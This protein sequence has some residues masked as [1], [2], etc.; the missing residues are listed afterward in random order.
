MSSPYSIKPGGSLKLKGDKTK[1]VGFDYLTTRKKKRS[2]T[3]EAHGKTGDAPGI[4]SA[5]RTSTKAEQHFE[6]VQ[7][8]R[9]C[10]LVCELTQLQQTARKEAHLSHKDKIKSFNAYLDSLSEHNDMPKIGPG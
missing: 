9:V 4:S 5:H 3:S 7:R 1:Y 8:K 10:D 6:E 2:S